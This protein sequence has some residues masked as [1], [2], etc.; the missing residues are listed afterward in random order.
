MGAGEA[1]VAI[2]GL[3]LITVVTR[4]FFLLPERELPIPVWLREALRYAPLAALVAVIVPEVIMSNGHLIQTW[5]DARLYAA[6]AGGLWYWWRRGILGTIVCGTA[7][8]LALRFGL[9]W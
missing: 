7:V 8:L 2:L 5:Q 3:G 1:V 4:A 6:A 9:G